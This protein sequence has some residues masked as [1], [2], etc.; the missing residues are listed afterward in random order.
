MYQN[1]TRDTLL[2]CD[3]VDL[4]VSLFEIFSSTLNS[5][6]SVQTVQAN[7]ATNAPQLEPKS[8][9]LTTQQKNHEHGFC[10]IHGTGTQRI[11]GH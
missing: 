7:C 3:A 1:C 10:H 4:F 11:H 2:E 8:D 9:R 6:T 5:E